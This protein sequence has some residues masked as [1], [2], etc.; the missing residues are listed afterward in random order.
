MEHIPPAVSAE[1]RL[2]MEV[3]AHFSM[4]VSR[5]S[6]W[7]E[8]RHRPGR[9]SE[10]HLPELLTEQIKQ[11]SVLSYGK[12]SIVYWLPALENSASKRIAEACAAGPCSQTAV[13]E[14]ARSLLP[15]WPEPKRV[16]FFKQALRDGRLLKLPKLG[17]AVLY[18]AQPP[19]PGLYLQKPFDELAA[20]L[21]R[22]AAKLAPLGVTAEEFYAA[23]AQLGQARLSA[24]SGAPVTSPAKPAAL[25][26]EPATPAMPAEIDSAQLILD[27]V[28]ELKPTAAGRA[29][30]SLPQLR[31]HLAAAFPT[32][33]AFD[34]AVLQL[35]E[36]DR[37]A[38]H[39]HDYPSSLSPAERDE[40][41]CD[42]Q[43]R[44]YLAIALIN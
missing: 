13:L 28:H 32:K 44:Y 16:E 9:P 14:S 38:L 6:I 17:R 12:R 26:S 11:G 2:L 24:P 22:L 37:V 5:T 31:R 10:K 8:L 42:T 30:V 34:Q 19:D 20:Q 39:W 4:P 33:A 29:L 36:E 25:A 18:S 41:V 21:Q 15:G 1:A 27:G 23:A 7:K 43:G 35:A 3:L 40:L